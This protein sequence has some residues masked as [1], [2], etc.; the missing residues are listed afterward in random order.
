M[1][2][3]LGELIREKRL[4]RGL[5][6]GQLASAV[7][8][9]AGRVRRWERNEEV[10]EGG[11]LAAL[12]DYL[13]IDAD[14]LEELIPP[15]AEVETAESQEPDEEAYEEASDTDA[16]AS[17]PP[18]AGEDSPTELISAAAGVSLSS[19]SQPEAE[20]EPY[21]EDEVATTEHV[22]PEPSEE[23]AV[24]AAEV[25]TAPA[26]PVAQVATQLQT[27]PTENESPRPVPLRYPESA[28]LGVPVE[29]AEPA[30]NRWNPLRYLYD[31]DKPWI[32]WVRAALTVLV[33]LF[34]LNVLL[35]SV[36][37]LFDKLGE[38]LDT[39]EPTEPIEG[40]EPVDET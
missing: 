34:L 12:A 37:E 19:V 38:V 29:I 3:T 21:V 13:E 39:I 6:L 24:P 14:A 23:V 4:G 1:T 36:G 16:E 15:A 7:A 22:V 32:Y 35:D 9:T 33:L 27:A 31:P 28:P 18:S 40:E 25:A 11:H 5:S 10:P 30:P 8:T 20:P 17:E 2:D 26:D